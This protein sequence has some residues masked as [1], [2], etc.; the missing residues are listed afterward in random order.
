MWDLNTL[1]YLNEQAYLSSLKLVNDGLDGTATPKSEPVF[2]LAVL[3]AK[4]IVGPP[5]LSRLID[6]LE[7]SDT[8]AYFLELVREYLPRYEGEIMAEA[9][10]TSRILRFCHYFNSQYFPLS[11]M[12]GE[13]ELADFTQYIPVDLMGFTN[14]DYESFNDFRDGFILLL[15]LV[16]SPYDSN[17]RVP[18]L[19]RVKELVGKNLAELIPADGWDLECIHRMLEGTEYEG[20]AVFA[21]WVHSNT[22]CWQLDA[23]YLNYE[24]EHW[25]PGIIS[26]LT[27]Q[28]PMVIDLQEKMTNAYVWLE[29]DLYHN[30]HKLLKVLL[31]VEIEDESIP[32]EQIPFPLDENGQVISEEVL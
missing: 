12:C 21:D 16:E 11:D 27:E 23:D 19:E 30:F 2:P 20:C 22:G 29:E 15:S 1:R 13:Y 3:A 18:I 9:D 14:E 28:W 17:E 7:D 25:D 5:S 24:P 4:L 31:G 32:K 8:V 26:S 10:D 6:I